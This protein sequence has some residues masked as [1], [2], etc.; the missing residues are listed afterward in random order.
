VKF[1]V[2]ANPCM[3]TT[4]VSFATQLLVF[5]TITEYCPALVIRS[6]SFV[7]PV[8]QEYVNEG[9]APDVS[10]IKLPEHNGLSGPKDM[11]FAKLS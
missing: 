7:D 11:L 8:F 5:V 9:F 4:I 1:A 3:L 2:G 10:V 6:E